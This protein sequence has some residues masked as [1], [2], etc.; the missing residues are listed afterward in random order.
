M[1]L[2]STHRYCEWRVSKL[3]LILQHLLLVSLLSC[4][5]FRKKSDFLLWLSNTSFCLSHCRMM[6]QHERCYL[7]KSSSSGCKFGDSFYSVTR[8]AAESHLASWLTFPRWPILTVAVVIA[9]LV[10]TF[11]SIVLAVWGFVM[12]NYMVL[13]NYYDD[14]L[15]SLTSNCRYNRGLLKKNEID[16]DE[17]VLPQLASAHI[18]NCP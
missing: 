10:W 2:E 16:H 15:T 8:T 1:E 13:R 14:C 9:I 12:S 6:F 4:W 17:N 7:T 11:C 18:R 5:G 3:I